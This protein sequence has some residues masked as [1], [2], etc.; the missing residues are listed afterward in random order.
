MYLF[1]D[2]SLFGGFVI[3]NGGSFT[4]QLSL[5]P[6]FA[7]LVTIGT[8]TIGILIIMDDNVMTDEI[9]IL[10]GT[11]SVQSTLTHDYEFIETVT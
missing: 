6:A 7:E 1:D 11:C 4:N 8:V 5:H 10:Q 3:D 2:N 9:I